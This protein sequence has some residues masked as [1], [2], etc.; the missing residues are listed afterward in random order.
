MWFT[1]AMTD[2]LMFHRCV[3]YQTTIESKYLVNKL[4]IAMPIR[5]S[6]VMYRSYKT[7]CPVEVVHVAV[8]G[9]LHTKY[10]G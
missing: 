4:D 6:Q 3:I 2:D 8:Y 10:W 5:K 1:T 9:L 7:A